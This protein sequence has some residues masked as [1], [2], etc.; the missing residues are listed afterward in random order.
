MHALF[1]AWILALITAASPPTRLHTPPSDWSE[2]SEERA[3]RLAGVAEDIA[4]VA[5]SEAP[6]PF[7]S[8]PRA[9]SA[10]LLVAVASLESD[11]AIDVDKGPCSTRIKGR[12]DG[13]ASA[14]ILQIHVGAGK[15]HQGWT[16]E[17]LFADRRKCLRAGLA[18]M[19]RSMNACAS[20]P[21][22][23]RLAAYASGLCELGRVR[24]RDR[25]SLEQQLISGHPPPTNVERATPEQLSRAV[26]AALNDAPHQGAIHAAR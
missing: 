21:L 17:E 20:A 16:R 19:R 23:D 11:F 2:T 9:N 24:S 4:Q 22:L 12:C 7:G 3:T 10:A 13:G 8:A 1:V 15:T 26:A 18:L 5:E 6:L 25:M 14:C